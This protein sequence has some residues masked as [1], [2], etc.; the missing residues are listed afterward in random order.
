M[1]AR[2]AE[3]PMQQK[4]LAQLRTQFDQLKHTND[5]ALSFIDQR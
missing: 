3:R 1:N 4:V 5:A 2:D